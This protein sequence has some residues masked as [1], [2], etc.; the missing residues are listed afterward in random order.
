VPRTVV[1]S[2]DGEHDNDSYFTKV[3]K[4]LPGEV[5]ALVTLGF[6]VFDP[7]GNWLWVWLGVAAVMNCTYLYSLAL[8]LPVGA[9]P[10]WYFYLLSVGAFFAWAI[11]VIP[12]AQVAAHLDGAQLTQRSGFILSATAFGIPALDA[13][14]TSSPAV[15]WAENKVKARPVASVAVFAVC[16][17]IVVLAATQILR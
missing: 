6:G 14:F 12:A 13:L 11:A 3:G 1:H 2:S 5:V 7:A 9:R 15:R 4:Y 16:G 8:G 10:R 17:A